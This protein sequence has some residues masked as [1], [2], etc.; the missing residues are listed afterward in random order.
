MQLPAQRERIGVAGVPLRPHGP[1]SA[2]KAHLAEQADG[3]DRTDEQA[4][5]IEATDVLYR[6][7]TRLDERAVG[8]HVARLEQHVADRA[9]TQPTDTAVAHRQHPANRGAFRVGQRHELTVDSQCIVDLAHRRS[10][11]AA[12]GHLRGFVVDDPCRGAH[13]ACLRVDRAADVPLCATTDNRHRPVGAD[14]LDE[15]AQIHAPSGTRCRSPHREPAG[16][17]FVG[18]DTPSGSNTSRRRAWASR[19]A[20][21]NSSGM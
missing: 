12:H 19:S 8:R 2:A 7:P 21:E 6:R 18:F 20:V 3:S 15:R 13:G 17:T 5:E 14:R 4:A 11:A 10:C 16:S 1:R 9:V